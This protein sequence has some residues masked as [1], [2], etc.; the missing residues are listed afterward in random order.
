[1]KSP[2]DRPREFL[3]KGFSNGRYRVYAKVGRKKI[4]VL[5]E[6]TWEDVVTQY[7]DLMSKFERILKRL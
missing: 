1:M 2:I 4:V 3:N 6:G 5:H 7:A